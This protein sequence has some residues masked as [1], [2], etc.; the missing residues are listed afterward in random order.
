VAEVIR[1]HAIS[2]LLIL[3]VAAGGCVRRGES[4]VARD[5]WFNSRLIHIRV[6]DGWE[7]LALGERVRFRKGES[8]MTLESLWLPYGQQEFADWGRH[9]VEGAVQEHRREVKSRWVITVDA[10]EAVEMET[11]YRLDHTGV[12]RTLFVRADRD[13]I[14]LR[15]SGLVD[16]DMLNAFRTIRDSIHFDRR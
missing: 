11:W 5:V 10:H 12:Q 6:P 14:V 9:Q 8:S 15:T 3:L 16:A 13:V 2:T 7:L 1:R 4:G